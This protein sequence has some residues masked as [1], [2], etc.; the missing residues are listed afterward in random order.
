M[1]RSKHKLNKI[2]K[3]LRE[4]IRS[5]NLLK[6]IVTVSGGADS[7]TLLHALRSTKAEILAAHCNFHLRGDESMRDQH[8]VE[9]ICKNLGVELI[10]KDFDVDGFINS[11]KGNSVEMACRKL[12]Y[13]WFDQLAEQHG[14]D[15]IATGHNADD[16]I[17]TLFLNLMRGSGTTGLKGMVPDNGRIWRPLLRF[18]R[19]E[20][21]GYLKEC[22]I[23]FITD[24]SNLSSDYRRNFLR[25]EVIP[26]LRS[27]WEGFDKAL[28]RSI[29][30]LRSENRVVAACVEENLPT[31][32]EPLK[33]TVVLRFPDPEL[34]VRRYIEP[35]NPFTTTAG[36]V[37]A[38]IK[39]NKPDL[40]T[41]SLKGGKLI[42]RNGELQLHSHI[43]KE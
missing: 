41:W 38:A 12:R 13:D 5:L 32:G 1:I 36:E 26:M 42:L 34:L 16:N 33:A 40:K 3:C 10:V 43:L 14:A 11:S 8:H 15:R 9:Q 22:G 28:D 7:L 19:H 17:E 20:I 31:N 23:D 21:E 6:I 29:T 24:S 18:H 39:A 37:V 25:N 4:D 30:L 35:L 2:E 27:R